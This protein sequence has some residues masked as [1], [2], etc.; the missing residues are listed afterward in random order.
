MNDPLVSLLIPAYHERFFGEALASALAQTYPNLEIVVCDDS[1]GPEIGRIATTPGA[2]FPVR[3]ERNPERLGAG[4]N[5]SRCYGLARGEYVKFLNDDDRLEPDCVRRM[6]D[7]IAGRPDVALVTSAR[8]VI[9]ARGRSLPPRPTTLRPVPVD[10]LIDGRSLCAAVVES[11]VNFIGEPSATLFRRAALAHLLPDVPRFRGVTPRGFGDLAMWFTIL[12]GGH[13]IYL[14]DALSAYRA[15]EAQQQH[16]F[17]AETWQASYRRL[18]E[19]AADAGL[20]SPATLAA[21][22]TLERGR[23]SGGVIRYRPLAAP[24]EQDWTRR[25]IAFLHLDPQGLAAAYEGPEIDE[26]AYSEARYR[27]LNPDL[28]P[29]FASRQID[30]ETHALLCGVG[31]R[32]RGIPDAFRI[33][34]DTTRQCLAAW[35]TP[36]VDASGALRVCPQHPPVDNVFSGNWPA[37]RGLAGLRLR[38][39]TGRLDDACTACTLAAPGETAALQASARERKLGLRGL[40]AGAAAGAPMPRRGETAAPLERRILLVGHGARRA[41]GEMLLLALMRW[42]RVA[43]GRDP[44]AILLGGGE[45]EAEYRLYGPVYT[46]GREIRAEDELPLLFANLRASG[47]R[48]AICNTILCGH[49]SEPL[50]QAGFETITLIHELPTSIGNLVAPERVHTARVHSDHLVFSARFVRD[51]FERHYGAPPRPAAVVAQGV[52]A[53]LA[54]GGDVAAARAAL[55]RRCGFPAEA[56]VALGVGIGDLRKGPDL[57]VET[58]RRGGPDSPWRFVWIGRIDPAIE[59]WLAHD[60]EAGGLADRVRLLDSEA[61]LAPIFLAADAFLL[62]SREDPFPNVVLDAMS[63]GLPVIA[64]EGAGGAPEV[65]AEGAGLVVP[66]RDAGAMADRLAE[67]A[68]DPARRGRIGE[69][70]RQRIAAGHSMAGYAAALFGLFAPCRPRITAILPPADAPG[71][72]EAWLAAALAQTCPPA[73]IVALAAGEDTSRLEAL[74]T[75]A[76]VP[77]RRIDLAAGGAPGFARWIPGVR[78]AS[79]DLVWLAEEADTCAPGLLE[80]LAHAFCGSTVSLAFAESTG[81]GAAGES[82]GF[83]VGPSAIGDRF[84]VRNP[85][86][87]PAAA[88]LRRSAFLDVLAD[89][90]EAALADLPAAG[91]WYAYVR[92]LERGDLYVSPAPRG[93]RKDPAVASRHP[94]FRELLTVQKY[95]ADRH[96]VGEATAA[97]I[98]RERAAAFAQSGAPGEN[99]RDTPDFRAIFPDRTPARPATPAPAKATPAPAK[100]APAPGRTPAAVDPAEEARRYRRAENLFANGRKDQ[101]KQLLEE[102]AAQGTVYWEVYNDLGV[103][104]YEAG[105]VETAI[106]HLTTGAG[107]ELASTNCLRNLLPIQ[108][109]LGEIGQALAIAALLLRRDPD[110]G[111]V[112]D[113]V[114]E[115]LRAAQPGSGDI[116]WLSPRHAAAEREGRAERDAIRQTLRELERDLGTAR[117]E[118]DRLKRLGRPGLGTEDGK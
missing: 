47:Y 105:D 97:A 60:I 45:L 17:S 109:A 101:A 10:A 110:P 118:L 39:L 14:T 106:G 42:L 77:F 8:R 2:R 57:F 24:A 63:V 84:A 31:E 22:R 74:A 33:G 27:A 54:D 86:A 29:L 26:A 93:D 95:I 37:R 55:R 41:G 59:R 38:L 6:V 23:P 76:A 48:R 52:L 117:N 75:R 69:R 108:V 112:L 102:M 104:A 72:R 13:A 3:Y 90:A 71:R 56:P 82:G 66:Y 115:L 36:A 94:P 46:V 9:D 78:A 12:E 30:A 50:H 49:L 98:D 68:A 96:P 40:F 34:S 67:L 70:A 11:A 88:L 87:H 62:T 91:D 103:L 64:Y 107:L 44:V 1:R 73:E 20:I 7:C 113:V 80:S 83:R 51:A 4:P 43:E 53:D 16:G 81:D 79:G 25:E 111:P 92:L 5:L 85:V 116:E 58:A 28:E 21:C 89:G 114:G 35:E 19:L 15:H 99:Y 65:L 32:R 100:A 61:D 18:A